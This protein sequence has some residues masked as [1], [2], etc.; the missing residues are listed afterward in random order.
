MTTANEALGDVLREA[1]EYG[2]SDKQLA[3]MW[4]TPEDD[5]RRLRRETNVH[6][7][8]YLV[9]TC[10][11]EFEAYTPYFY[12]TYER[13]DE[14]KVE[15]RRKVLILGGG[16]NRIGQ[17]IE[18]DYCCCHASF[19]LRD[20]GVMAIMSVQYHPEAAAGPHDGQYLFARFR[21][22]IGEAAGA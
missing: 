15:D 16:P 3:E 7:T 1:K 5:I 6:P 22:L 2:F 12:S 21:Q 4:K 9:D 13:G 11:A 17:G 19:A 20:A 10:A 14:I 8:Y 18:F